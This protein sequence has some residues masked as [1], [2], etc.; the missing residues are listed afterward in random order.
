MGAKEFG[1]KLAFSYLIGV[2]TRIDA[3]ISTLDGLLPMFNPVLQE[4]VGQIF[5]CKK[6]ADSFRARYGL[7]IHPYAIAA[8]APK[9]AATGALIESGKDPRTRSALYSVAAPGNMHVGVN[10]DSVEQLFISFRDYVNSELR[11]HDLAALGDA[12]LD[13]AFISR[14]QTLPLPNLHHPRIGSEEAGRQ[15]LALP[16]FGNE[17]SSKAEAERKK[18]WLNTIF[19][20]YVISSATADQDKLNA[21]HKIATATIVT[22]AVLNFCGPKRDQDLKNTWFM[23]DSPLLMDLLDLDSPERHLYAKELTTQLKKAGAKI[24]VFEHSVREAANNI[25]AA[26]RS[27]EERN[28]HGAIGIRMISSPDFVKRISLVKE[29]IKTEVRELGFNIF[30]TPESVQALAFFSEDMENHLSNNIGGYTSDF[31]RLRDASSIAGVV[32]L[33]G[34][35]KSERQYIAKTKYI[36]ITRNNRLAVLSER[37]LISQRI[38]SET[39]MPAAITDSALAAILWLIL[40][41]DAVSNLPYYRLLAN[42]AAIPQTDQAI[43]ERVVSLLS[44]EGSE[45]AK[46]FN[47]WSRTP[48]GAEVMVQGTL[49]DPSL[50]QVDN[51]REFIDRVKM[52]AGDEAAEAERNRKKVELESQAAAHEAELLRKAQQLTELEVKFNATADE[53]LA[54]KAESLEKER[55]AKEEQDLAAEEQIRLN[56]ELCALSEARLKE[57]IDIMKNLAAQFPAIQKKWDYRLAGLMGISA[58]GVGCS[59][60]IFDKFYTISSFWDFK[61]Q[62]CLYIVTALFAAASFGSVP[63]HLFQG[64]IDRKKS[65]F[66][67]NQLKAIG[68]SNFLDEFSVNYSTGEI[69]LVADTGT[70]P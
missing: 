26:L 3:G 49:G 36:F 17:T 39:D 48:R 69:R 27:Y 6:V 60:Y 7:R 4:H 58:A 34:N 8:I 63:L 14:L 23:L 66:I 70:P 38:Y 37:F 5:D 30:E 32:R 13:E 43:R 45:L 25:K 61:V 64:F 15:T 28:S 24:A 53:V 12:E 21:F 44:D 35:H 20:N 41:S 56:A 33:R 16:R 55:R 1:D 31:A 57:R 54:S 40:G 47:I 65:S 11:K 51:L 18:Q 52:A 22:E 29:N 2:Q 59:G 46:S 9:L 42:C 10:E 62:I 19:S 68:K 50:I 67:R